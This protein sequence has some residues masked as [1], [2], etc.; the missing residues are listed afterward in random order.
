MNQ[1]TNLEKVWTELQNFITDFRGKGDYQADMAALL[2]FDFIG[3]LAHLSNEHVRKYK[4][5]S[6][7]AMFTYMGDS[8]ETCTENVRWIQS[9][10]RKGMS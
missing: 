9:T 1:E 10:L 3:E 8:L 7:L 2:M 6:N 4:E 5:I